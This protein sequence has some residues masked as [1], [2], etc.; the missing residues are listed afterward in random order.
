MFFKENCGMVLGFW[1]IVIMV[2][3]VVGF[4]F[5]GY[6]IENMD[7]RLIF[8]VNVLIGVIVVIVLIILLEEFFY[9]FIKKFDYIGFIL[10][11]IGIVSILYILGKGSIIDWR[12]IKNI[13]F[14]MLGSISL[15][16]FIINELIILEFL[17]DLRL[18]KRFDFFFYLFFLCFLVVVYMGGIYVVFLFL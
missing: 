7:W 3:F 5:G 9:E 2:V 11:I 10:L 17:L 18:L 13:F 1:G 14:I 4:I 12:N 16:L 8:N 15:L 6:I